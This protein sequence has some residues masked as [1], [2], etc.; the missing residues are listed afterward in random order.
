MSVTGQGVSVA[1]GGV[2]PKAD[3]DVYV[4]GQSV[5]VTQSGVQVWGIIVPDQNP[6]YTPETPV[7]S[8]GYAPI[9]P[10]Q[11]AGYTPVAPA[12]S[13]GFTPEEPTQDPQWSQIAA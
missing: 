4:V 1:V 8:A 12:Q 9:T 13:P 7:Q 11:S 3:A 10:S 5:F 6:E 2:T